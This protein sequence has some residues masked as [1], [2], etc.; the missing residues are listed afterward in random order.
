[1]SAKSTFAPIIDYKILKGI[2]DDKLSGVPNYILQMLQVILHL[3]FATGVVYLL[4]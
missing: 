1:M 3:L 2:K 4:G